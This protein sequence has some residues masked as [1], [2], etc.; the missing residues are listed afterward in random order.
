MLRQKEE[1]FSVYIMGA[2]EER[3]KNLRKKELLE[4][5]TRNKSIT[6]SKSVGLRKK[7]DTKEPE[8]VKTKT[9]ETLKS[10]INYHALSKLILNSNAAHMKNIHTKTDINSIDE[11]QPFKEKRNRRNWDDVKMGIVF[12]EHSSSVEPKNHQISHEEVNYSNECINMLNNMKASSSTIRFDK[13]HKEINNN[14]WNDNSELFSGKRDHMIA[15]ESSGILLL[16]DSYEM[17]KED[18]INTNKK[19]TSI[20]RPLSSIMNMSKMN[21]LNE[22]QKPFI[23]IHNESPNKTSNIQFIYQ[24]PKNF[25]L[26]TNRPLSQIQ[27]KQSKPIYRPLNKS[28]REVTMSSKLIKKTQYPPIVNPSDSTP[29]QDKKKDILSKIEQF[30]ERKLNKLA[31]VIDKLAIEDF[32]DIITVTDSK[33]LG[34]SK[35]NVDSLI[36]N[37]FKDKYNYTKTESINIANF[38]IKNDVEKEK[39]KE[40]ERRS[41]VKQF[42]DELS[43]LIIEEGVK[44]NRNLNKRIIFNNPFGTSQSSNYNIILDSLSSVSFVIISNWGNVEKVGLTEIELFDTNCKRVEIMECQVSNGS[45]TGIAK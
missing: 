41:G 44:S 33:N 2:N 21:K 3:I 27:Q 24:S 42:E 20:T 1:G 17:M 40:K 8:L 39:S 35:K 9:R 30:D 23:N 10:G 25:E 15:H 37:N 43:S 19:K 38:D 16:N 4:K 5:N 11:H 34:T 12:P 32:S 26:K 31:K 22:M 14:F 45:D 28:N 29:K 18:L 36:F 7:W 6:N 13:D